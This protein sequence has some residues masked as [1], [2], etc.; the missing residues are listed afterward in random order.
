MRKSTSAIIIGGVLIAIIF[1]VYLGITEFAVTSDITPQPGVLYVAQFGYLECR[2]L[3][4]TR[5]YPT[6][7]FIDFGYTVVTCQEAGTL[8]QDCTVRVQLPTRDE[9]NKLNGYLMF[10]K[11]LQDEPIDDIRATAYRVKTAGFA[12]DYSGQLLTFNLGRDE[13]LYMSFREE[14]V[15]QAILD[16]GSNVEKA[17][18]QIRYRPFYIFT[19]DSFRASTGTYDPNTKDCTFDN[20]FLRA[21]PI[22]ENINGDNDITSD[23]TNNI[24]NPD[25]LREPNRV[26]PYISARVAVDPTSITLIGNNRF[27]KDRRVYPILEIETTGGTYFVADET[28]ATAIETVECCDDGDALSVEGPG[29]I[30]VDLEIVKKTDDIKEECNISSDCTLSQAV[31]GIGKEVFYEE[32]IAGFCELQSMTVEC[33]SDS[34]CPGGYCAYD[35]IEPENSEC[36]EDEEVIFCG[37]GLCELSRGETV[38][39]CPVD[40]DP[41]EDDDIPSWLIYSLLGAGVLAIFGALAAGNRK[42]G[43]PIQL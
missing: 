23:V 13:A 32:C 38:Q 2:E 30:C 4:S 3:D 40:C 9:I 15:F 28:E 43:G 16:T 31:R 42:R 24:N 18:Y 7:D 6:N 35:P 41:E 8:T 20:E 21:N 19:K 34:Q 17:S 12:G 33:T 37:N 10:V 26:L 1:G 11:A 25:V 39:T 27:C 29:Y 36:R 5:S 14:N 22:I